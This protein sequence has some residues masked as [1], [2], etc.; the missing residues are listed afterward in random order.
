MLAFL[1]W[2]ASGHQEFRLGGMAGTGKTTLIKA[3][4]KHMGNCQVVTPTAKAAEVLQ[5]KEVPAKTI[6][7][8]FFKF[9]RKT[10]GADGREELIF[11]PKKKH[12]HFIIVDESSMVA[13]KTYDVIKAY[14]KRVVW[15]GDHFQLQ[16]VDPGGNSDF[17][18]LNENNLDAELTENHRVGSKHLLDF[19]MV[20]R[21][22]GDPSD[23]E[24]DYDSVSIYPMSPHPECMAN[25]MLR[26]N[27]W[28]VIASTNEY[29]GD[30]NAAIRRGM[31]FKQ[32]GLEEGL[33]IVCK[34]N[35][36]QWPSVNGQTFTVKRVFDHEKIET[37][38]GKIFPVSF[39]EYEKGVVLIEDGYAL[40][41]HKAQGSEWSHIAAIENR[42]E[43]PPW[44]YTAVT[45]AQNKL[46]YF[47]KD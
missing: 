35:S 19:A 34:R 9:N 42:G 11:D 28:P 16:P 45:R 47:T 43:T 39:S 40:T 8:Q 1:K 36:Y 46:I 31:G 38:C 14:S 15:V 6:H 41:C 44:Q 25:E 4:R 13:E 18:V 22:G 30:F 20:L 5:Q 12:V 37:E 21:R 27:I 26:S 23:F 3:M 10:K 24:C 2:T 33:R 32:F 7:S 29:C 17:Q